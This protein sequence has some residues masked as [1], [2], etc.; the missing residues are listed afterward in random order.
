M[1]TLDTQQPPSL[2]AE[3]T[4]MVSPD[5]ARAWFL[6]L[7]DHPERYQFESHGGF[8][9]T[10]GRFG[11][12]GARFQTEEQ[13]HGVRVT[14]KFELVDV[15]EQ[16]FD[17][18]VLSPV[19]GIWGYFELRPDRAGGTRLRL[20]VGSDRPL[21]RRFLRLPLVSGAVQRQISQ[22]VAHIKQSME[23]LYKEETWAS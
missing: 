15:S 13:F 18:R 10:E 2:L 14:L 16:R 21:Q 6:S 4:V 5:Q 7:A 1:A 22:E 17:F 20:G 23:S 9:F 11:D 12:P 19:R 8:T 3:A